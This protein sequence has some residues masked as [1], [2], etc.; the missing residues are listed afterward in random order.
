MSGTTVLRKTAAKHLVSSL[1]TRE[2]TQM[3]VFMDFGNSAS[4]RKRHKH[5]IESFTSAIAIFEP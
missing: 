5:A 3:E 2:S 4:W 1:T